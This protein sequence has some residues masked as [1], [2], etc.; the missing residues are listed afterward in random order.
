M[1]CFYANQYASGM[2]TN[3][4]FFAWHVTE[5]RIANE[6]PLQITSRSWWSTNADGSTC[7]CALDATCFTT[8]QRSTIFNLPGIY[9]ACFLVDAALKSTLEC[10]YDRQCIEILIVKFMQAGLDVSLPTNVTAL[11]VSAPSQFSP[12][13]IFEDIVNN[14]MVENYTYSRSYDSF[15]RICQ[16]VHCSYTYEERTSIL[17][18]ITTI[19][20]LFGGM[21]IVLRLT[22]QGLVKVVHQ[23][24]KHHHDAL[25]SIYN[26]QL[27]SSKSKTSYPTD[28]NNSTENK[29]S[30]CLLLLTNIRTLNLYANGA[31]Q[32]DMVHRQRIQTRLYMVLLII[33][34]NVIVLYTVLPKQGTTKTIDKPSFDQYQLLRNRYGDNLQCPCDQISVPNRAFTNITATAHQVCS[35]DFIQSTWI[36]RLLMHSLWTFY[37]R[38]DLRVRGAAY[39]SLLAKLCQLVQK[40]IDQAISDFL[41]EEFQSSEAV[42]ERTFRAHMTAAQEQFQTRTTRQFSHSLN[43]FRNLTHASTFISSYFLNWYSW[44]DSGRG[45]E[46]LPISP[47]VVNN[48]CSCGT[49]ID[50]LEESG[51]IDSTTG[52]FVFEMPG[53]RI[54][55]SVAETLLRSSLECLFDQTCVDQLV[56][57]FSMPSMTALDR[58]LPSRF[59]PTDS[60]EAIFTE[61]FV[62]EWQS[63]FSY[64]DFYQACAPDSCS[65]N[66]N[67]RR[68]ILF[69]FSRIL[70]LYGGLTITLRFLTP[71]LVQSVYGLHHHL[72]ERN[73]V[74]IIA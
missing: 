31:T 40:N 17:Y 52:N 20:G 7:Y 1:R 63:N 68:Q 41:D 54:G 74:Q 37:Q 2:E 69:L 72:F 23:R 32:N 67:E 70:G 64:A 38:R 58:S 24:S 49:R 39:Y 73:R 51:I 11:S 16:P 57:R 25:P 61:L 62:E 46:T 53:L 10:W 43:L 14:L 35:S 55:C 36:N 12:T 4:L 66:R 48:Q 6:R 56:Y 50:C 65:Y 28:L 3:T 44:I 33:S 26:G 18:M 5:E 47:V 9:V 15:Y 27:D 34:I 8:D 42:S 13:T 59:D 29:K 60:V 22:S 19:I 21:N 45:H 30:H 71:Y